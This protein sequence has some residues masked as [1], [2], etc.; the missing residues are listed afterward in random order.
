MASSS[1]TNQNHSIVHQTHSHQISFTFAT[2]VKLDRSNFLLWRKQVLT[3]IRGNRLEGFIS[4]NQNI[5]E[6]YLSQARTDGSVE[7]TENPAYVNWR[8]QD[9]T[10]LSWLFSTISEGI[11]SS[12]LNYDTAFDVWKSIEK[13][14][15]VQSEAKVMQ[16]RYELDTLRK[17]SMSIEEY[18]SKMKILANK[19]ACAGDNITEKDLLIR[20]LNGLGSG[21]LDL[22]SIITANKMS[23]DDAYAL[24]LTHEARL[25]QNQNSQN[26]QAMFNANH[27]MVNANYSQMRGIPRRNTYGNGSFGQFGGRSQNFGRGMFFNSYPRGFP[28]GSSTAGGFGR[29][30]AASFGR[31]QQFTHPLRSPH[32]RN[33]FLPGMSSSISAGESNESIPVCQI[34]HKQGHTADACWYRYGDNYSPFPKQF[35]RGK[36]MG[37]KAA[38][39]TNFEPFSYHQSAIED[40]YEL[41]GVNSGCQLVHYS[42]VS[43][44]SSEAFTLPEAYVANLEDSSD[45]GWYLDSGATHHITNNMANMHVREE[46]KGLD[47]LTIGNGQGFTEGTGAFARHSCPYTHHQNGVVER[48][49]RHV[50]ESGLTL[51][52]QAKLPLQFWWEAFQTAVYHINMLPSATLKFL[53]PYEKLFSHKPDYKMLKCFGC[54]CYPYLR[55]YNKHKFAYHSSKCIFIGYSPSHKGYKC[56]HPS[57][58]TYI[59]RHVVFYENLFPYS[60]D[61]AFTSKSSNSCSN[62]PFTPQQ[63]YHLSTLLISPISDDNNYYNHDSA[64][65]TSST[66]H[67]S[68]NSAYNIDPHSLSQTVQPHTEPEPCTSPHDQISPHNQISLNTIPSISSLEHTQYITTPVNSHSMI[69]RSKAGIFKPKLYN[70]T[71][72]HK[73]PESV[74]EAMENPKWFA[75]MKDE[76]NALM[77]NKT[78]SLVPRSAGQKIVGNKWVFRVKQNLDGSLAK[79]KARLVAKGFQQIEGVNYFE[80]FS[81]VVKSAT[82]RVVISLAVMKQWEIRQVDVNNAFLNGELTE[83]V[84]MDQPAG[85]VNNQKPEFVCK[86]HKSLYGLKQAPR[87]WYEK[88]KSCLLQWDFVNS[89]ADSSLF[90]KKTSNFMIMVLIYVDDILITGPDS[91]ALET[92]ITELSRVFALKDLGNLSYFLGIEVLYDAGCI[93]LSQRKYIRDL[94]SK[95]QLLE[96]KGIDTPMSTGIKLQK[97]TSGHLGQYITDP[98]HYRSIVGGMQYLILTRPEIAF[99][100]NKLSQYVS[101]STLQH[102]V[103]CKRVLRYLKSTQDYGLKFAQHGEMKITGFTDADWAGDLDDRKSV[104]AYCI[105]LGNNLISWSSKKQSVIARSSAESEYRALASASAEISWLQSLFSEIGLSCTE[106]PSVWCDNISATE[107]ARNP[108]IHSRTKHIEIDLHFIRDK[109]IAGELQIQYIPSAEQIADIMTKPLSFIHFNYLRDKLNVQMCP[110]S[111]RGAVKEAHCAEL[112]KNRKVKKPIV[113][114]SEVSQSCQLSSA[115]SSELVMK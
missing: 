39:M 47:Q 82:V 25:E 18:C 42:P 54:A 26:S 10:L 110:L 1:T 85:F 3:S 36:M 6:Q 98:T 33:T 114:A 77:D 15:G 78:W 52:A 94:L 70:V 40:P 7:R 53:T 63:V 71:L 81:P 28:A 27:S 93:Y 96:C 34:C 91:A 104:G 97:E 101:T 102:L 89:R 64:R 69:T 43:S 50:V 84:F 86:L 83:E 115:K 22:A 79:Y 60:S 80:T 17:E 76:Y 58:Q 44:Y 49:H 8:A 21:Y 32:V 87:A 113:S 111:L 56:L 31:N 107:L 74:K 88:L 105:Y 66:S 14:F 100:V 35:G 4:E 5:P 51:L 61:S 24:L 13:Q 19:L 99:A 109:V 30:H 23:Y 46:F 68:G 112:M 108:V 106:T 62:L 16:L 75:A 11:L 37:P 41:S 2:T 65:P 45:E 73:E 48:K 67:H 9:Q 38:Y 55:D 103:A 72:V 12:V 59:A 90:I 57:G 29:G 20:T 95:V 92:F